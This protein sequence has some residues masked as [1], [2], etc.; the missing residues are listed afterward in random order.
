MSLGR[1]S[2]FQGCRS[3]VISRMSGHGSLTLGTRDYFYNEHTPTQLGTPHPSNN[4][5]LV[6]GAPTRESCTPLYHL[7]IVL[8]HHQAVIPM[9]L[10]SRVDLH[11]VGRHQLHQL[12]LKTRDRLGAAC[13]RSPVPSAGLPSTTTFTTPIT[14]ILS[15]IMIAPGSPSTLPI[16]SLY[17]TECGLVDPF[18]AAIPLSAA[19][20][21]CVPDPYLNEERLARIFDGRCPTSPS[22]TDS[23][24]SMLLR[25]FQR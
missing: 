8:Y 14:F 13:Y 9:L 7:T 23:D 6:M 21:L 20:H 11:S 10:C 5:R 15:T 16:R 17:R 12:R 18:S 1:V 22:R 4:S 24:L 25:R 19:S 3:L 2:D